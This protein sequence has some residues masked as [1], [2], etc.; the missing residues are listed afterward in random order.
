MEKQSTE[1][2]WR[3]RM[4]SF[5]GEGLSI[6]EWCERHGVTERRFYY[7]R[8]RLAASGNG[9]KEKPGWCAVEVAPER[10]PAIGNCGISIY[11]GGA[12][13]EVKPE[14]DPSALRAV[15]RALEAA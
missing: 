11:I 5:G 7:W 14:F 10:A 9:Q 15:V 2:E 3:E 13:I 1:E 6:R 12:R 4:D 8:R